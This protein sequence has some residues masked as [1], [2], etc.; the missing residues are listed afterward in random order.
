MENDFKSPGLTSGTD[1]IV[2]SI[3]SVVSGHDN[4]YLGNNYKFESLEDARACLMME[5]DATDEG[6]VKLQIMRLAAAAYI[7]DLY[8]LMEKH[9]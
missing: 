9:K 8:D 1:H 6:I 2:Y 7:L 3:G 4:V 5:G